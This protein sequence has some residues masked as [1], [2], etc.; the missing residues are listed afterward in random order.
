MSNKVI[1]NTVEAFDKASLIYD[2]SER[3]NPILRWMRRQVYD[4]CYR[5][6]KEGDYILELNCGTGAD[7]LNL[8]MMNKNRVFA[9]DASS[10]MI[11]KLKEKL[12]SYSLSVETGVY[13]FTDIGKITASNT[14][15]GVLSNFGGLNCIND[16]SELSGNLSHIKTGGIFI[17]VVMNR[18]CPWEIFYYFTKRKKK[19]AFRRLNRK[20][21]LADVYGEKIMTYYYSPK[22]FAGFFRNHFELKKIYSLGMFTPAPYMTRLHSEYNNFTTLLMALDEYTHGVYPFNRYGDH[23]ILVMKRK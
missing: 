14:F 21:I 22:Q 7:A 3:N 10:S 13:A 8:A 12:K 2:E 16:H 18:I 6:F 23:F 5:Y 9:T 15:D 17:A 1:E 20:G 11:D 19:E 4:V